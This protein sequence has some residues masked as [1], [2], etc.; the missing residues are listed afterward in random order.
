MVI[1][2]AAAEASRKRLPCV[3]QSLRP[4]LVGSRHQ[5]R[6]ARFSGPDDDPCRRKLVRVSKPGRVYGASRADMKP[7]TMTSRAEFFTA[8]NRAGASTRNSS[9]LRIVFWTMQNQQVTAVNSCSRCVEGRRRSRFGG[10]SANSW[11]GSRLPELARVWSWEREV[12]GRIAPGPSSIETLEASRIPIS[13]A[14]F[15]APLEEIEDHPNLSHEPLKS[16]AYLDRHIV[17]CSLHLRFAVFFSP[18]LAHQFP[19]FRLIPIEGTDV[20]VQTV[21]ESK[22]PRCIELVILVPSFLAEPLIKRIYSLRP[23]FLDEGER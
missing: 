11:L 23:E 2:K 22:E 7:A 21:Y 15:D 9:H 3:L 6:Y 14:Q 12:A 16:L 8:K 5:G 4:W 18:H 20:S 17:R 10:R 19:Q 13:S 1:V